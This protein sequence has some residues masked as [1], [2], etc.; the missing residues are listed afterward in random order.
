MKASSEAPRR[1]KIRPQR[2]PGF[3]R[4][5]ILI[6]LVLAFAASQALLVL[7]P[8]F[9]YPVPGRVGSGFSLRRNPT[10]PFTPIPE[11]H[12][13]IDIACPAGTPVRASAPGRVLS[14]GSDAVSGNYV[15]VRHALGFTSF[16]AHLD[17]LSASPGQSRGWPWSPALGRSGSTGRS[18]GPHLHFEIRWR[19][20][21][22]P[23]GLFLMYHALRRRLLGF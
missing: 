1:L 15:L 20:T 19:G 11:F 8:P 7:F 9:H 5:R 4:R 13:G 22:L 3:L 2:K 21:P 10:K 16:Y 12:D 17:S 6:G 14:S 18:S 23:P